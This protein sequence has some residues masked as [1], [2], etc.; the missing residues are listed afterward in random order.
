[1]ASNVL[2]R[3]PL[4]F[5]IGGIS[6]I[7]A[8]SSTQFIPVLGSTRGST[9]DTI[10]IVKDIKVGNLHI[11]QVRNKSTPKCVSGTSDELQLDGEINPDSTYIVEKLLAEIPKC[12]DK[13]DGRKF[14]T[15]V[16]MNSGGGRLDDGFRLGRIFRK[17]GVT[18]YVIENQVCASSCAVAFLGAPYRFIRQSGM[19][20]FHSPYQR[21]GIGIN[22]AS[23]SEAAN[24]KK[25]LN[26]MLYKGDIVFERAMSYCSSSEGWSINSDAA[27]LYEITTS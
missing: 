11:R 5:S 9:A 12:I 27:R 3:L 25:Y 7:A 2:W 14:S 23:K 22:C 15:V 13:A 1:M 21:S 18:A 16:Y 4:I 24:L 20:V 10:E 17:E 8:C 6:L 19:L 26:D